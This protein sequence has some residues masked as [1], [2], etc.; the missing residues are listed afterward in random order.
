MKRRNNRIFVSDGIVFDGLIGVDR[1]CG[2]IA[3]SL[4]YAVHY[5]LQCDVFA[6]YKNMGS[7]LYRGELRVYMYVQNISHNEARARWPACD[8]KLTN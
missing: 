1:F 8:M 3:Q 4:I 2:F 5:I 7:V 6:Y